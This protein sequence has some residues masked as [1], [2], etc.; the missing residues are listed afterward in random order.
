MS[1]GNVLM[2][3]D[4]GAARKGLYADSPNRNEEARL[5]RKGE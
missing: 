1:V 5:W 2:A 3:Q 4:D